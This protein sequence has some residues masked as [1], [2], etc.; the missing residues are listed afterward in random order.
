MPH[1][2]EQLRAT[3]TELEKE[4]DNLEQIDDATR[5]L[6]EEAAHE[7]HQALTPDDLEHQALIDNLDTVNRDFTVAHPRLA[8]LVSKVVDA[9]GWLYTYRSAKRSKDLGQ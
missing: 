4:L 1:R 5:K 6:L 9:L 7:I 3:V 8:S 2:I